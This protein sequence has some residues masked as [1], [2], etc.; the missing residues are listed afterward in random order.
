[1]DDPGS[2]NA[3]LHKVVQTYGYPYAFTDS[4]LQDARKKAKLDLFGNVDDNAK[5]AEGVIAELRLL[6]HHV[7]PM[8]TTR[9]KVVSKLGLL[10][11]SEENRLRKLKST[12]PLQPE[13]RSEFVAKWRFK[14][15]IEIDKQIGLKDGPQFRFMSG[16]L[17][18]PSSSTTTMLLT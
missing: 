2:K 17:F 11:I 6:G 8:F 14:N 16:I 5:F 18:T 4:L 13:K 12:P 9:S 10:I 1:M 15:A 3:V 7:E